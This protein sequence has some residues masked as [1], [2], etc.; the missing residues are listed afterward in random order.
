MILD[1]GSCQALSLAGTLVAA[2][3]AAT[4]LGSAGVALPK[5]ILWAT[6]PAPGL[7]A[8]LEPKARHPLITLLINKLSGF[9]WRHN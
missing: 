3:R 6:L 4:A 7:H 5:H 1:S 2:Q 8:L 9:C